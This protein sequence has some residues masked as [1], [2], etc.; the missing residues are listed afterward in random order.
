MMTYCSGISV[1]RVAGSCGLGLLPCWRLAAPVLPV[2]LLLLGEEAEG[3]H[4]PVQK[5]FG[6]LGQVGFDEAPIR[7]GQVKAEERD[8]LPDTC[9]H[10]DRLAEVD[11]GVTR[12]WTRGTNT[13]RVRACCSRT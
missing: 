1:N 6:A 10:R 9:D 7:V 3:G 12:G 4:M 2:D 13:S 11:L 5:G 8:G